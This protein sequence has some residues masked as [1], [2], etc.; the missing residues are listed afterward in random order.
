MKKYLTTR[1]IQLEELKILNDVVKVINKGK[2][3]YSLCTGTLLGA[4]RH[5]G[6]IPWD[7]DI[8]IIMPREDYEKFL[9]IFKKYNKN[10]NLEITALELENL[11]QPFCKVINTSIEIQDDSICDSKKRYL[12]IDI[13]PIDKCK[14]TEYK[15]KFKIISKMKRIIYI[16]EYKTD[17][18]N[19][20]IVKNIFRTLI[21]P[22]SFLIS[23]KT[24]RKIALSEPEGKYVANV[25]WGYGENEIMEYKDLTEY[26]DVDFEGYI[27]KGLKA[28]DKY[29]KK[30]YG[31]YM[32]LP[33][34]NKRI[35][36]NIRAWKLEDMEGK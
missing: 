28:Y 11:F 4:I 6:F 17:Y 5:K 1:E 8:D 3:R 14:K 2:L 30:L 18:K 13:F 25:V 29:L 35:T 36:H 22:F 19:K 15:Y 12:W 10:K 9:K 34:E 7:D 32:K 20:E 33:P 26:I 24:I 21:R 27:F 16:R 23:G 31:N